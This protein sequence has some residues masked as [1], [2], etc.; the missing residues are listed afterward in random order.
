MAAC[1]RLAGM[2]DRW[3]KI[4]ALP[5]TT[6][7]KVIV[8]TGASDGIGAAAARRLAASG[9]Q[10]VLTGR[11]AA[12]TEAVARELDADHFV[13][14]FARLAEVRELASV[15]LERYPRIDILANNAGLVS[16]G[17]RR[18]TEDGHER[19]FQV[20]YLS[21]FLLTR[22]LLDRLLASRATV[23][24]TS[25]GAHR[26]GRIDLDDLDH[27][28]HYATM[29]AYGDSKLAQ[30]L[31]TR[32]L[33]RRYAAAGLASAAFHPGVIASS[34]AT[35]ERGPVSWAYR[36]P[37][38]KLLLGSTDAGADT[39]VFL[40]EGTAGTDFPSGE[41]FYRRGVAPTNPQADDPEL[42]RQLWERSE[43]M[44]G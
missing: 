30:V 38:P 19:T 3:N 27:R 37:L 17:G 4:S 16:S 9:H 11:S 6:G 7:G 12:K 32:E 42:A 15:L 43:A 28:R 44:L 21:Q 10:V 20:N 33:H 14:D 2:A 22:L 1:P 40:A 35:A 36:G 26:M 23:I 18:V 25:S 34:F 29:R 39:L 41:Y 8:I 13:A 24:A 5:T 31:H